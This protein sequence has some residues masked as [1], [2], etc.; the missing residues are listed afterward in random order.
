MK[1]ILKSLARN[2]SLPIGYD[3]IVKDIVEYEN[4]G[5]LVERDLRIYMDYLDGHLYHFRDNTSG[6]EVDAILEFKSGEC[7]AVEIKLNYRSIDEAK[8]SLLKFYNNVSK[9][10]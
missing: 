1:M 2:E 8:Q 4:E 5:D 7:A 10:A 9:K 6:D 3:T